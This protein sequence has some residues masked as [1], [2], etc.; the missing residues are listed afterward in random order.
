LTT[1]DVPLYPYVVNLQCKEERSKA[2]RCEAVGRNEG[3]L[4][5]LSS[6]VDGLWTHGERPA[7]VAFGEEG[8]EI[9]TYSE[10]AGWVVLATLGAGHGH[11]RR[12]VRFPQLS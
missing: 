11:L 2:D 12:T 9:W 3:E 7:L 1:E 6:V 4:G 5:T 8:V 10:L